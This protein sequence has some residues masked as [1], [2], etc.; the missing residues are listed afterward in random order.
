MT[1]GVAVMNKN[2]VALAIDSAAT[3]KGTQ[4]TYHKHDKLFKLSQSHPV[5]IMIYN[6]LQINGVPWETLIKTYQQNLKN[7]SFPTLEEYLINFLSFVQK[8]SDIFPITEQQKYLL[9]DFR[10]H[11]VDLG[12]KMQHLLQN[13][14]QTSS[15]LNTGDIHH[16]LSAYIENKYLESQSLQA[17][18]DQKTRKYLKHLFLSVPKEE[19]ETLLNVPSLS[20]EDLKR[21]YELSLNIS[22]SNNC[23]WGHTGIVVA[24]FGDKDYFPVLSQAKVCGFYHGNLKYKIETTQKI[25]HQNQA[26]I[27]PFAQTDMISAFIK[28]VHPAYEDFILNQL[29]EAFCSLPKAFLA[30]FKQLP[31]TENPDWE[32]KFKRMAIE[33]FEQMRYKLSEHVMKDHVQ[34]IIDTTKFLPKDILASVAESLIQVTSFKKTVSPEDNSVGGD[35]KTAVISKGDGLVWAKH[36]RD[37]DV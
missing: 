33:S 30:E 26:Q 17:I 1:A 23:S 2:G 37:F 36:H 19:V 32:K 14:T 5:G 11:L 25:T 35:I 15:P 12:E 18:Y 7:D 6:R 10:N 28:G 8:Q 21:I 4:T 3:L 29:I 16:F 9:H 22:I 31:E 27:I 13:Y 20:S 34:P 24:G